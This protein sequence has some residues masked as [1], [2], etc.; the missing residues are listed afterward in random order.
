MAEKA[1]VCDIGR[2]FTVKFTPEDAQFLGLE[3]GKRLV[4]TVHHSGQQRP[5]EAVRATLSVASGDGMDAK[6]R[7]APRAFS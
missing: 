7:K 1:I 4:M 3:P 2:D 5:G 6:N